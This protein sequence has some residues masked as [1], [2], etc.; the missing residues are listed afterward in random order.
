MSKLR[1]TTVTL[2]SVTS[3]NLE[4]TCA[5]LARCLEQVEFAEC[6]LLTHENDVGLRLPK[7]VRKIAIEPI[8]SSADYSE[9]LLRRLADYVTTDHVLVIQWDGFILDA[10][11]WDERFLDFDYIGAFWP[12]FRDDHQVGNGGFSLR[13]RRLLLACQDAR[14]LA[15]HPEDVAICRTNRYFLEQGCRIRFADLET[16]RHFSFEREPRRGR[17]FGFHGVFNLPEAVGADAFW[18]VYQTLNE[19]HSVYVDFATLWKQLRKGSHPWR[20]RARLT[21]D[22]L[23]RL[24]HRSGRRSQP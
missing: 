12:Q 2:V 24:R 15:G 4:A 7:G 6:L 8:R 20:R 21:A 14:F 19:P 1:L 17:T 10:N 5:A 23:A 22:Y 3:V 18:R 11:A 9:F 16:A 13:S